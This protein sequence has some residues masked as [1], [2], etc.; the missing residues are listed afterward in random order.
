MQDEYN[1]SQ[2][3]YGMLSKDIF[4]LSSTILLVNFLVLIRYDF[5]SFF[6]QVTV[7]FLSFP[8]LGR[9]LI[10]PPFLFMFGTSDSN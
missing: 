6:L 10:L 4:L 8:E 2:S 1:C 5:F 9:I 3:F 7:A